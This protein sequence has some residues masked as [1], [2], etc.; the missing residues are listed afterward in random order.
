MR[1]RKAWRDQ[2]GQAL[3]EFALLAPLVLLMVFGVLDLGRFFH[4]YLQLQMAAQETVRLGGLGRS[5]ADMTAF[6]RS[7][8]NFTDPSTVQ[9]TITP[10]DTLREP[11]DY[12]TVTLQ[13]PHPWITPM[14][15]K[16]LSQADIITA[17]S[18]IRVE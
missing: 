13:T 15:D 2:R 14:L 9:V 17:K 16:L 18:T 3:T 12:V 1:A 7:Y 10:S 5:D 11:G 6:A 4:G 8:V